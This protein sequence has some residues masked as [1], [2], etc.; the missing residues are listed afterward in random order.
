MHEEF[1]SFKQQYRTKKTHYN[2]VTQQI[3]QKKFAA[4]LVLYGIQMLT[5]PFSQWCFWVTH[6]GDVLHL[7]I[8]FFSVTHKKCVTKKNPT[9]FS[10]T[11]FCTFATLGPCTLLHAILVI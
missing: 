10:W 8:F 7:N 5:N 6:S 9:E 3:K 2:N 4:C 1:A 11:N